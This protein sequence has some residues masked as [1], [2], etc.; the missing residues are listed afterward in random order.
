M[1]EMSCHIPWP[2]Y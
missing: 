2:A 1:S